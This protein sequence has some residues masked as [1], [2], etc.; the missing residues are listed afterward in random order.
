MIVNKEGTVY[1]SF[2]KEQNP[3]PFNLYDN[4]FC[5]WLDIVIGEHLAQVSSIGTILTITINPDTAKPKDILQGIIAP[6]EEDTNVI[7]ITWSQEAICLYLNG[8]LVT[9]VSP[10]EID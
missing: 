3:I 5:Y 4:R 8:S 9:S 1:F 10:S 2:S 6:L 7:T